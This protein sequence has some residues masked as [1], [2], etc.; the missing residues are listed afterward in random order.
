M[1]FHLSL[2]QGWLRLWLI[3]LFL[4]S[5]ND[6]V[7][8][9]PTQSTTSISLSP[10]R[11]LMRVATAAHR[12]HTCR[13]KEEPMG[14]KTPKP[15]PIE[16]QICDGI[17]CDNCECAYVAEVKEEAPEPTLSGRFYTVND[18]DTY[19]SIA[20]AHKSP[21]QSTHSY[22]TELFALNKGKQLTAGTVIKL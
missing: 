21:G 9:T 16:P 22:A 19:A 7:G 10:D 15:E 11:R 20:A 13:M 18:G 2:S 3:D 5:G 17:D 6:I 14:S 1:G 12:Q 8:S 4:V